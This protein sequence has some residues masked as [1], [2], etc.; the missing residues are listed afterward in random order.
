MTPIVEK[1]AG[2]K[3]FF[4]HATFDGELPQDV[5]VIIANCKVNDIISGN[6]ERFKKYFGALSAEKGV[7]RIWFGIIPAIPYDEAIS[8]GNKGRSKRS[9]TTEDSRDY[10]VELLPEEVED[11][12]ESNGPA[13]KKDPSDLVTLEDVETMLKHL[14][15]AK[16]MTFINYK[17]DENT[18]F[19]ELS[20]SRIDRY[21]RDFGS[22]NSEYAV[23]VYPNFTIL[24][25][26]KGLVKIGTKYND[27]GEE[28]DVEVTIP[29]VYLDASYVACGMMVGVQNYKLLE[30]KGYYINQDYPCVRFDL[31]E[32][33]RRITTKLNRETQTEMLKTIQEAIAR[34]RFGFVFGDNVKEHDGNIL[35]NSYVLNA[36]SLEREADGEYKPLYKTLVKN[37]VSQ[38][39]GTITL[40]TDYAYQADIDTFYEKYVKI[41]LQNNKFSK[42]QYDNNILDKDDSIDVRPGKNRQKELAILFGKKT[43]LSGIRVVDDEAPEARQ[44]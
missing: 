2:V 44:S 19:M 20:A 33:S 16:I 18:G 38:I 10:K 17:A 4:D 24:P 28:V 1:F 42:T 21:R 25:K 30:N 43:E 23:F 34:N 14:T 9:L 27:K 29:G 32:N 6:E 22:M 7:N 31:E 40:V 41:W 13:K 37:V 35:K 5:S 15:E 12:V 26:E 3:S 11:V 8:N 39:L 36:R